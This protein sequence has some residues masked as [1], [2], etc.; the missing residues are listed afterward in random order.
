MFYKSN[1][2]YCCNVEQLN[3]YFYKKTLQSYYFTEGFVYLFFYSLIYK[4]LTVLSD[5]WSDMN[6]Y[7]KFPLYKPSTLICQEGETRILNI[8][9]SNVQFLFWKLLQICTL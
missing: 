8:A 1:S 5:L 9:L 3:T 7:L 4:T 6:R 2:D